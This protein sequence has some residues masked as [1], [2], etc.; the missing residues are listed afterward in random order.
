MSA[1]AGA[2]LDEDMVSSHYPS[3]GLVRFSQARF[4]VA[5][6]RLQRLSVGVLPF[7]NDEEFAAEEEDRIS[8]RTP[9]LRQI[10]RHTRGVELVGAGFQFSGAF[11]A[12]DLQPVD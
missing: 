3:C 10:E 9:A 4:Q 7:H 12:G 8:R 6:E 2:M 1:D 5:H 11:V